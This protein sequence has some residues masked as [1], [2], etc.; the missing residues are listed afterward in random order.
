M[1]IDEQLSYDLLKKHHDAHIPHERQSWDETFLNIAK[2][3]AKRSHDAQTQCGAVLVKNNKIL[4]TGYNGFI[5]GIDDTV[6]A[7]TRPLKY[8]FMFHAEHNAVLN[9]SHRPDDTIMYITG[10]PC[11]KC[12][13]IMWQA[14][15]R[16]IVYPSAAAKPIMCQDKEEEDNLKLL[17]MLMGSRMKMRNI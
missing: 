2:E 3:V 8:P 11:S 6:L 16:E 4:S 1:S 12:L 15:V 7:N 9:C 14:G 17:L 10:V 13:Q 5:G